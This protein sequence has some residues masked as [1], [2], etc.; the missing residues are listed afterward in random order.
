MISPYISGNFIDYLI[1]ADNISKIYRYCFA[2]FGLFVFNQL[3]GYIV[4]RVYIKMQT[5]MGYDLKEH[6][7]MILKQGGM[8]YVLIWNLFMEDYIAGNVS[9]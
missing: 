8:I 3:I 4:N 2:F 9:M 6:C 7:F 1:V 5:Q